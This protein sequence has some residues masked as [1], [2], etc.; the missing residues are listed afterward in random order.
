MGFLKKIKK[1]VKKVAKVAI[2]TAPIWS[3][4]IPGGG[5]AM[6]LLKQ[7]LKMGPALAS[8]SAKNRF[9]LPN[10]LWQGG[11]TVN[12]AYQMAATR[13]PARGGGP[14]A[15]TRGMAMR[16][17]IKTQK[18]TRFVALRGKTMKRSRMPRLRMV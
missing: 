4:F 11:A 13:A 18:R 12:M 3:S 14:L 7:G 2:K 1:V 10:P 17:G 9:P 16:Q 8:P 15:S 5:F 6:T